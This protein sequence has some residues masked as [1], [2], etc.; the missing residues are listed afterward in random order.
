MGVFLQI[1]Q[2][3]MGEIM[4]TLTNIKSKLIKIILMLFAL[5]SLMIPSYANE[6]NLINKSSDFYVNDNSY[7]L[8]KSVKDHIISV[9]KNFENTFLYFVDSRDGFSVTVLFII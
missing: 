5:V 8:D 6:I 7:V 4:T 9:N 1:N 2:I 3:P